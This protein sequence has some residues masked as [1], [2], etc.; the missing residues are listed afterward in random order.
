MSEMEVWDSIGAVRT[1]GPKN[2]ATMILPPG[3]AAKFKKMPPGLYKYGWGPKKGESFLKFTSAT[4]KGAMTST[5]IGAA[6]VAEYHWLVD[7]FD[8]SF[9]VI[10]RGI[11]DRGISFFRIEEYAKALNRER[12]PAVLQRSKAESKA[13]RTSR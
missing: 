1:L 7:N 2:H 13:K 9:P 3:I 10:V 11:D 5:R 12:E 6:K 8:P 4:L